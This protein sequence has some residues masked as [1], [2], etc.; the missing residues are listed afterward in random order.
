M[1]SNGTPGIDGIDG[2]FRELSSIIRQV[3]ESSA[4]VCLNCGEQALKR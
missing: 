2:I 1:L 4:H 3:L